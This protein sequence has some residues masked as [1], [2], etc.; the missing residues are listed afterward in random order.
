[1]QRLFRG[2]SIAAGLVQGSDV[3]DQYL[4]GE[5]GTAAAGPEQYLAPD[6]SLWR[7]PD[8]VARIAAPAA[9]GPGGSLWRYTDAIPVSQ[10]AGWWQVATLGEGGTPLVLEQEHGWSVGLK[11]EYASP[12]GSFKDR[13]AVVMLAKAREW[14]VERCVVDSSGNAGAA[15]AAYAARL[16][17][18]CEVFVPAANSPSKLRQP[19]SHGAV[20]HRI[21]GSREDVAAAALEFVDREGAFYASHVFNPYFYEGT[22][23]YAF[24]IWEQLGGRAPELLVLPVGN[25][26]FVL[27]ACKGFRE[28]LAAGLVDRVPRVIAVQAEGCAPLA[29]AHAAGGRLEPVQ[30]RPTVAE[31]IAIAQPRRGAEILAAIREAGGDVISVSDE[32]VLA[33]RARLAA[34]GFYVEPTAAA[35]YAGWRAVAPALEQAGF[36][37]TVVLPLCGSGLKS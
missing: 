11:V 23:T 13:G 10:T 3:A 16:G 15:V 17:I 22:K 21:A 8:L 2:M 33:A 6:G 20:V 35:S 7:L 36:R 26:T 29:R 24:E 19:E 1:M 14:G 12:T 27:G 25:G 4:Y 9:G 37:G 28:L 32:Q 31:G 34:R 30:T 18:R 5:D